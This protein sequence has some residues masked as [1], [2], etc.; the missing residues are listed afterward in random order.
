[1]ALSASLAANKTRNLLCLFV[2]VLS[3]CDNAVVNHKYCLLYRLCGRFKIVI[4]GAP[5]WNSEIINNLFNLFG[6]YSLTCFI[7]NSGFTIA[8]LSVYTKNSTN[9]EYF[10]LTLFSFVVTVCYLG[11]I[12]SYVMLYS[13]AVPFAYCICMLMSA[14]LL[15]L[16]LTEAYEQRFATNTRSEGTIVLNDHIKWKKS[17][18]CA[19]VTC[20]CDL[21]RLCVW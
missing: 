8:Y 1:M 12:F 4:T 21:Y 15:C 7:Y 3:G 6:N 14:D 11:C 18:P 20:I 17:E 16:C 9:N 19:F 13:L 10:V 2:C 5:R